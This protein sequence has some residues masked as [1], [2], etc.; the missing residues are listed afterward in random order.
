MLSILV[1]IKVQTDQG[2]PIENEFE[3]FK[4]IVKLF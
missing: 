3:L 2:P 4:E 1:L